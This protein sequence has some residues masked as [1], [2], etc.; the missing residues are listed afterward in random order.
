MLHFLVEMIKMRIKN[1]SFVLIVV[2][3]TARFPSVNGCVLS[4]SEGGLGGA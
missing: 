2:K 1:E 3:Y 4:A